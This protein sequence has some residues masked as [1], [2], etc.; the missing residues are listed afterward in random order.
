MG[1][2]G[3]LCGAHCPDLG[4]KLSPILAWCVCVCGGVVRRCSMWNDLSNKSVQSTR[5][6]VIAALLPLATLQQWVTTFLAEHQ[7]QLLR[8]RPCGA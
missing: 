7:N 4:G 5:D 6:T 1:R 2:T 8:V 3:R